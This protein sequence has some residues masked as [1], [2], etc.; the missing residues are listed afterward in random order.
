MHDKICAICNLQFT[1]K[2]KLNLHIKVNHDLTIEQ[3]FIQTM[4]NNTLEYCSCKCGKPTRFNIKT[5]KFSKFILGHSSRI[6]NNWGHNVF[7]LKKSHETMRILRKKE[8]YKPWCKGLTKQTDARIMAASIKCSKTIL[9]N[10]K[11]L[12]KRSLRMR[13]LRLSGVIKTLFGEKSSQWRGGTS[14]INAKINSNNK[15]YKYW[16]Y[17]KLKEANFTCTNCFS[18]KN[19]CVHHDK[20]KMSDIIFNVK[21]KL[22][23]NNQVDD[24]IVI[25]E[26]INYH[27]TNNV[28]GVVLCFDCHK[29]Q[30]KTLNFKRQKHG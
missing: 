11:E 5:K 18:T 7:A 24:I 22:K 25:N 23:T 13:K 28:S 3:Y 15:L 19:L 6:K 2:C 17:P 12:N 9:S 27:L 1:T 30:H 26:V 16:K 14:S 20:E 29:L 21:N 10:L 8:I 4:Y